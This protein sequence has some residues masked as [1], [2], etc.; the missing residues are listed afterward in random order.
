MRQRRLSASGLAP[1][2]GPAEAKGSPMGS[3]KNAAGSLLIAAGPLATAAD[4]G[5]KT[6]A[7]LD[8]L[9]TAVLAGAGAGAVAPIG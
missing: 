1:R 8:A 5:V 4:D 3:G 2:L 7:G 9:A 6:M